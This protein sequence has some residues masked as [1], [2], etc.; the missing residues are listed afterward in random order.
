[1]IGKILLAV[2]GSLN[3]H[4]ATELAGELANKLDADLFIVHVLMNGRPSAELARMA[5]VEHLVEQSHAVAYPSVPYVP[6][7]QFE[8]LGAT[9][10]EAGHA[11]LI[12]ALGDQIVARAKVQSHELGAPRI[13]TSTH[14]GDYADEILKAARTNAADMIVIG[15]RGLG[16][17]KSAVLGS[18]SQKVL[19]HADCS[20][21]T[22]R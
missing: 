19:H 1:M 13:K 12:S 15:S 22:V 9:S 14:T 20:V 18:V 21:L 16:V 11:R 2:D 7:S 6:E 5:E 17:I 4:R 3:S 8:I 10:D